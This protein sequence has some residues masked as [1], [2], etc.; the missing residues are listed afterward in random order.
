MPTGRVASDAMYPC[1]IVREL[2]LINMLNCSTSDRTDGRA[3]IVNTD[4][5]KAGQFEVPVTVSR[6]CQIT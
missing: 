5:L 6:A 2:V 3:K 1:C 4:V